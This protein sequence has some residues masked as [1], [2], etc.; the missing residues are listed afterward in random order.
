M[1]PVSSRLIRIWRI[2][3]LGAVV[4]VA[5]LNV[6]HVATNVAPPRIEFPGAAAA[7]PVVRQEKRFK[8]LREKAHLAGVSGTLGYFDNF[9]ANLPHDDPAVVREYYLAQFALVPW[10]LDRDATLATWAITN[11]TNS[12]MS[13]ALPP[14]WR[15]E[16]DCGDGVLLLRKAKP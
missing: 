4:W 1:N 11:F 16:A 14:E 8:V 7:D 5:G 13:K 15:I 6:A 10:V 2:C 12:T 9:P 3:A